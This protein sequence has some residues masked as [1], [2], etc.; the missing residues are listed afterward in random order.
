MTIFKGYT[1]V[2]ERITEFLLV[3][4]YVNQVDYM[5]YSELF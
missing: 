1:G 4:C 3:I 2:A 5:E